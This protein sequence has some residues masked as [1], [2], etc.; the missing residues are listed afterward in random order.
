MDIRVAWELENFN[1]PGFTTPVE[2]YKY[3]LDD[4]F[5]MQM[6]L[7]TICNYRSS[8]KVT[9]LR[10]RLLTK[11]CRVKIHLTHEYP[12]KAPLYEVIPIQADSHLEDRVA[13]TLDCKGLHYV[14][15][16]FTYSPK[17]LMAHTLQLFLQDVMCDDPFEAFGECT[18]KP[19]RMVIHR[20]DG[21]TETIHRR[22]RGCYR[23]M[24]NYKTVMKVIRDFEVCHPFSI[25]ANRWDSL[26]QTALESGK[27]EAWMSLD[28][29]TVFDIHEIS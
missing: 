7:E 22:I 27:E 3:A 19:V 14:V 17:T 26:F 1:C 24:N 16:P 6:T 9:S 29:N 5:V 4:G 25:T 8:E 2:V 28:C 21:S 10:N 18:C 20:R 23:P 11:Y 13:R 12:T 15:N